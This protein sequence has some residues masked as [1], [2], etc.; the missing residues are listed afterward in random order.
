MHKF[1]YFPKNFDRIACVG[2]G[3]CTLYC[4]AHFD[5][6]QTIKEIQEGGDK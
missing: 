4:P 2:C 5:I 6:R 3:R 1:N